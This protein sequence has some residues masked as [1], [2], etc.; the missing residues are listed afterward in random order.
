MV[1]LD[2]MCNPDATSLPFSSAFWRGAALLATVGV[3]VHCGVVAWMLRWRPDATEIQVLA[4]ERALPGEA[5]RLRVFVRDGR[6]SDVVVPGAGVTAWWREDGRLKARGRTEAD[7][8]A[9]IVIPVPDSVEGDTVTC[10]VVARAAN[11]RN[12]VDVVVRTSPGPG[13]SR[14]DFPKSEAGGKAGLRVELVPESGELVRHVENL[15]WVR[16]T[17]ADGHPVRAVVITGGASRVETDRAG[18]G[19]FRITPESAGSDS[20]VRL[21]V[22]AREAGGGEVVVQTNLPAGT[23][24]A[25][26]LVRPE[27]IEGRAGE[28]VAAE[29][30]TASRAS[31]AFVDWVQD[32]RVVGTV[33]VP[34]ANR[35]GR[36]ETRLA[37]G[38]ED[39]VRVEARAFPGTGDLVS[40]VRWIRV[41]PPAETAADPGD[42]GFRL[43]AAASQERGREPARGMTFG[44]RSDRWAAR[45]EAAR[46]SRLGWLGWLPLAVSVSA[47]LGMLAGVFQRD[48]SASA[49]GGRKAALRLGGVGAACAG[50]LAGIAAWTPAGFGQVVAMI[51]ATAVGTVALAVVS[52]DLRDLPGAVAG[53]G[54][55]RRTA[56][57][58]PVT[59]A[60]AGAAW[61]GTAWAER[62][63]A[64]GLVAGPGGGALVIPFGALV[65]WVWRCFRVKG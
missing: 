27:Q 4:P 47:G 30:F 20:A 3:L 64:E 9:E 6:A 16:T 23:R 58:V 2:P 14:P 17:D 50:T 34:L 7:G 35:Q 59:F 38:T 24:S 5:I 44:E 55:L 41:M 54:T 10:R 57:L 63:G 52:R 39:W 60:G 65:A 62:W 13:T 56:G 40:D 25:G 1:V 61:L 46:R 29:V 48:D 36:A 32:G 51:L 37:P 19:T 33:T 21:T 53:G 26:L 42:L 45:L 12:Q 43:A 18:V 15:V 28:P 11:G 8:V 22:S 49:P 31:R